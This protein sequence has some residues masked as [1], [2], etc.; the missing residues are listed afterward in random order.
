MGSTEDDGVTLKLL[1]FWVSPFVVRVEWALKL[2]GVDYQYIEE[3]IFNKSPQLQELN[4]VHKKVPVLV[5]GPKLIPESFVIMEYI[6]ETWKQNPLLPQDPYQ[7]AMARFWTKFAEEKLFE[8]A[9]VALCSEGEEHEL[10]LKLA[11]EAMERVEGELKQRGEKFFGGDSIGYLDLAIGWVSHWL[12]VF[13]EAG[14]M[15][16]LD[17]LKFPAIAA[18]KN[19]FLG[20]PAIRDKL[21]PRDKMLDYFRWRK[22]VLTPLRIS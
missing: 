9:W 22:E 15:Q 3:D 2:K 21:P 19:N 4:P 18:W 8:A 5:H 6:D 17:P 14:S 10:A 16:I 20:H 11:A 12:P 1:G 13:E 7:K